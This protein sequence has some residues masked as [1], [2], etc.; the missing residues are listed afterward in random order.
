[1]TIRVPFWL[2][3]GV[4]ALASPQKSV[5][6]V[7]DVG[8]Q[9]SAQ[10]AK[11]TVFLV[12][13]GVKSDNSVETN[14]G[15]GFIISPEGYV[16]TA[17]HLYEDKNHV[18]YTSATTIGSL[19]SS[20]DV[21]STTPTGSTQSLEYIDANHKVD[22]ALLKLQTASMPSSGYVAVHLCV[23]TNP[24]AA[25]GE[26]IYTLAFPLG[27]PLAVAAG[28]LSSVDAPNGLWKTDIPAHDGS[29]GGP[30][31]DGTTHAIG[32][33]KGGIP[34]VPGN[35]F[36]VPINLATDLLKKGLAS[37]DDCTPPPPPP[38]APPPA[39]FPAPSP[40]S[41]MIG[42]RFCNY[43][44]PW[45][46]VA[47]VGRIDADYVLRGWTSLR[48]NRC[49]TI[50]RYRRG[51]PYY[52]FAYDSYCDEW[53]GQSGPFCVG[54]KFGFNSGFSYSGWLQYLAAANCAAESMRWFVEHIPVGV[55]NEHTERLYP[56]R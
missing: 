52:W 55:E 18:P 1:M 10:Y 40:A 54:T 9:I 38:P 4:I 17:S 31:F 50:E 25:Q 20:F 7:S 34:N 47:T 11:S 12:V 16:L 21:S 32:V 42:V 43:A 51:I 22:V 19:G 37:T 56:R 6:Q 53:R 33:I 2:L 41:R 8:P 49:A 23:V 48:Y 14:L 15:T 26:R 45:I 24:A 3:M 27:L 5:A 39:P 36:F 29:S 28:T 35:T 46:T 30:V 13:R 44:A